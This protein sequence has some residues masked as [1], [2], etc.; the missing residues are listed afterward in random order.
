MRVDL[1]VGLPSRHEAAPKSDSSLLDALENR[2]EFGVADAQAVVILWDRFT[3]RNEI[4][5][6]GIVDVDAGAVG[7]VSLPFLLARRS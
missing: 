2:V 6:R 1:V 7:I 3:G 4:Y 5:R